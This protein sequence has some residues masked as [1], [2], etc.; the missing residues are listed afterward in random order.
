M[1]RPLLAVSAVLSL[2]ACGE[3]SPSSVSFRLVAERPEAVSLTASVASPSV[4]WDSGVRTLKV[5]AL[6]LA[7][8]RV[9]AGE[10]FTATLTDNDRGG[11]VSTSAIADGRP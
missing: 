7:V 5:T 9:P 11:S 3:E 6:E 8:G 4:Q 10:T 1:T 2:V